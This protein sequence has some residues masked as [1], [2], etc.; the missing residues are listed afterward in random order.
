MGSSRFAASRGL[1]AIA[2]MVLCG[3]VV[4]KALAAEPPAAG[5]TNVLCSVEGNTFMDTLHCEFGGGTGIPSYGMAEAVKSPVPYVV[6][7]AEAP[8]SA[9]LGAGTS[10]TALYRFQVVGP[11]DGE[12]V[13]LLLDYHLTATGTDEA[14]AIARL[15]VNAGTTF[16]GVEACWDNHLGGLCDAPSDVQGTF[17]FTVKTGSRFDSVTLFAQAQAF[18]TGLSNESARALADPYIRVDPAFANAMLYSVLVSPGFGNA[19]PV[20]EPAAPWLLGPGLL[21]LGWRTRRDASGGSARGPGARAARL[22][23]DRRTRAS[24]S[25]GAPGPDRSGSPAPAAVRPRPA[26]G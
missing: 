18:V 17:S 21:W 13:P 9:K 20:P 16:S 2:A 8:I 10:A 5:S 26:R 11:V 25:A 24:S 4:P 7:L 12:E 3:S 14:V 15:I 23:R 6:A 1:R 19:L 22:P